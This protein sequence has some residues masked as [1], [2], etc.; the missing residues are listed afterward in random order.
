MSKDSPEFSHI[1]RPEIKKPSPNVSLGS[2]ASS[3]SGPDTRGKA[4]AVVNTT[5]STPR[6]HA[7]ATVRD[8]N[9]TS[10]TTMATNKIP[11]NATC[12]GPAFDEHVNPNVFITPPTD[13]KTT[14]E[15][16]VKLKTTYRDIPT[17]EIDMNPKSPKSPKTDSNPTMAPSTP[18]KKKKK[19]SKKKKP[20]KDV[21]PAKIRSPTQEEKIQRMVELYSLYDNPFQKQ[22]E[23]IKEMTLMTSQDDDDYEAFGLD[24]NVAVA[25]L[26]AELNKCHRIEVDAH[27]APK[28][29][30]LMAESLAKGHA[31]K[32]DYISEYL[33]AHPPIK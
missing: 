9:S 19:K 27:L 1:S 24:R 28:C 17:S 14:S 16:K 4:A 32:V 6:K 20:V 25:N 26:E 18:A 12:E 11:M 15:P 10:K 8:P 33:Q 21:S 7:A 22:Y 2:S 5:P 3:A 31:I 29:A 30:A 23:K 13:A